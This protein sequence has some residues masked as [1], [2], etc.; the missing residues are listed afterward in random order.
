MPREL[1]LDCESAGSRY[2]EDHWSQLTGT[3]VPPIVRLPGPRS[4]GRVT[5][6]EGL[7]LREPAPESVWRSRCTVRDIVYTRG[8]GGRRR[9]RA[10]ANIVLVKLQG[11]VDVVILSLAPEPA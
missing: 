8:R 4:R 9:S 3:C 11:E 10:T 5:G 1:N 2:N 7:W 6:C